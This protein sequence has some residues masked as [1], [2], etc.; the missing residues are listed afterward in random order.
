ME[1]WTL[2]F[3]CG[4]E[5]QTFHTMLDPQTAALELMLEHDWLEGFNLVAAVQGGRILTA[6]SARTAECGLQ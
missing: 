2:I 4:S 6:D 3:A 5:V 1:K